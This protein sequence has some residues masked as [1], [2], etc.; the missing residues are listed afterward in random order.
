[1]NEISLINLYFK[2]DKMYN[3]YSQKNIRYSDVSGK[4]VK[5]LPFY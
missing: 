4:I 5:I 1:M 2:R 3:F